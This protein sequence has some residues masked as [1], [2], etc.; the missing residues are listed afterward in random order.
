[1]RHARWLDHLPLW[2][3][4]G[5]VARTGIFEPWELVFMAVPLVAA[6]V[7]EWRRWDL[8]RWRLPVE[9]AVIA[10]LAF[11][12]L[13]HP[14]FFGE[15]VRLLFLLSGLR[16]ALPRQPP[17]R[18]QLLLMGF[19]LFLTTAI[20]NADFEFF[21]WTL[22]WM[23]TATLTL[24]QLAW[25]QPAALR[26]GPSS[27]PPFRLVPFW[28]AGAL[29]LAGC[30][31]L[32]LP[33][34]NAGWRPFPAFGAALGRLQA[35]LSDQVDLSQQGP[36]NANHAVVLRVVPPADLT[37]GQ[38]EA[39]GGYLSYLRGVTL[40]RVD[41]QRW[42]PYDSTQPL[43]FHLG[44]Q[45]DGWGGEGGVRLEIFLNPTPRGLVPMPY[46]TAYAGTP[47]TLRL[48]RG[49]GGSWHLP[50]PV[51][52]GVPLQVV[53][54]DPQAERLHARGL[55]PDPV[56][57][58]DARPPMGRH[59]TTLLELQPQHEAARR[60][61]LS[62]APGVMKAPALASALSARLRAFRY[63]LD[64]PCG[65]AANPLEEFLERT[66]AGH[67]EYFASALALMLRAR[68]VPA[69]VVNGY[70]L[71]AWVPEGG[72]WLVTEDEAHSWVEYWDDGARVWRMADSTPALSADAGGWSQTWTRLAD[73]VSFKWDRYVVRFSGEDQ[74]A[75][76]VSLQ[77]VAQDLAKGWHWS[78]KKPSPLTVALLVMLALVW[79]A[80]RFRP[81]RQTGGLVEPKG[82][83]AFAPLLRRTRRLAPPQ[84]GETSRHWLARLAR[85]RPDR[86]KALHGLSEA[87]DQ[88]LYGGGR[89][90]A[91]KHLVKAE[92]RA[93]Q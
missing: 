65:A 14:G 49:E 69:R 47:F 41:G 63:T 42:E 16:L 20:S 12:L 77:S 46:G 76:L 56:P 38:R 11:D 84:P 68:G 45:Q 54:A 61:S 34:L 4:Y 15:M 75:G 70:R 57:L 87:A 2:A 9:L 86:A 74:A 33:R 26:H 78:W 1:M 37:A 21:A 51:A 39:L 7:V 28:A 60:A 52:R 30:F 24:L 72:Y 89:E 13:T 43:G 79:A 35:G 3:V 40:E 6:A 50:F 91:L 62:W 88:T 83:K 31:F 17:Q 32:L 5:A 90:S 58:D 55:D 80:W 64:N 67:C 48:R 22:L 81:K 85:L 44:N 36:I 10:W 66:Q 93:W 92:A 25:E 71:G 29:A 18:R 73:A 53:Q 8:S 59:L 23:I 19:L 27:R 82:V